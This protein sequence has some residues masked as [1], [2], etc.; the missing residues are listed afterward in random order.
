MC[1]IV[2]THTRTHTHTHVNTHTHTDLHKWSYFNT[3]KTNYMKVH[4]NTFLT[5]E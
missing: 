3:A 2:C 1:A 4:I 5:S